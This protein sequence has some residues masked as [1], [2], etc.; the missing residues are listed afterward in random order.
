MPSRS[1]L[2]PPSDDNEPRWRWDGDAEE[3]ALDDSDDWRWWRVVDS[4]EAVL[5]IDLCGMDGEAAS[6]TEDVDD[7]RMICGGW[8]AEE[9]A[10]D[11]DGWEGSDD[12][13][14]VKCLGD[15]LGD[16]F[17]DMVEGC[18][19]CGCRAGEK[20]EWAAAVEKALCV[21]G[22]LTIGE[23]TPSNEARGVAGIG[24][25]RWMREGDNVAPAA[26]ADNDD[27]D[28]MGV[29]DGDSVTERDRGTAGGWL[30]GTGTPNEADEREAAEA[31]STRVAM[32]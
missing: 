23:A 17:G 32:L 22:M 3:D 12:E 5:A 24:M 1:L 9:A 6:D 25:G 26:A 15:C 7:G 20:A 10:S 8:S 31:G 2:L 14:E 29:M 11:G 28:D 27:D 30:G 21:L 4:G 13:E 19:C 18:C 16:C